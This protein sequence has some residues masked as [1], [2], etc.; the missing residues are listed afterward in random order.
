GPNGAGK[1]TIVEILEG[2]QD[3]TSG[4]ATVLGK[5]LEDGFTDIRGRMGILPQEFEP[6]DMLKPTE[7]LSYF[8]ELFGKSLKDKDISKLLKTVGLYERRKSFSQNLSGGEKRKLGIALS[9]VSDPEF[10]FL[11]EPTTGLDAQ[12]R[13]SLWALI[14]SLKEKGKTI[15][16]TTHYLEEAEELADRVAIM[17]KGK[18]IEIGTP[19]E[20]IE[21]AGGEILLVLEETPRA[22][23]QAA[24]KL[25][26]ESLYEGDDLKIKVP[27]D[28]SV[29]E[30]LSNISK[31][32]VKF[33][34]FH[35][36]RP[37]LEDAFL[38]LVGAKIENGEL[39]E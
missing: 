25:K 34:D 37:T 6:F 5:K 7:F 28:Q 4:T 18:I 10:L 29:K 19:R 3:P 24:R 21:A 17:H 11:D 15:F 16:L 33:K 26:L 27:K 1:T 22:S 13:R 31:A 38:S 12:S 8:A 2:L 32:G 20:L 30:V 39:K 36:T 14:T 23:A 9:L 35:T